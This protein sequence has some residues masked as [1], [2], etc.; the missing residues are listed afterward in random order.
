MGNASASFGKL[1]DRLWKGWHVS[2]E[3]NCKVNQGVTVVFSPLLY[4]AETWAIYQ[5]QVKKLH[6]CMMAPLR[7]I[8]NVTWK[9]KIANVK[10]LC[11]TGLI[12]MTDILIAKNLSWLGHVHRIDINRLPRQLL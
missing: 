7:V 4:G 2:I 3:V 9:D 8:M 12:S 11:L 1:L 5:S 6:A 10:I